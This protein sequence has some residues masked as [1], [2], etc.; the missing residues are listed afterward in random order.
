MNP[1]KL[2]DDQA[3]RLYRYGN[4]H[5]HA[6]DLV[7]R[8]L[9]THMPKSEQRV[10]ACTLAMHHIEFGVELKFK[11]LHVQEHGMFMPI[12]KLDVLFRGGTV[13]GS[14]CQGLRTCFKKKDTIQELM[15]TFNHW[16]SA[17]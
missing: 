11:Y 7:Y 13:R 17:Y 4:F 6:A 9:P 1:V 3:T 16:S 8:K 5:F 12:H 15:F 2:N 10:T 14:E